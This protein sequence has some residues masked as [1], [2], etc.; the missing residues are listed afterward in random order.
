MPYVQIAGHRPAL[1]ECARWRSPTVAAA[2]KS[3]SSVLVPAARLPGPASWAFSGD[4]LHG[5]MPPPSSRRASSNRHSASRTL[6]APPPAISSLGQLPTPAVGACGSVAVA[7]VRNPAQKRPAQES[8]LQYCATP[9]QRGASPFGLAIAS[10]ASPQTAERVYY[11]DIV[12]GLARSSTHSNRRSNDTLVRQVVSRLPPGT[13]PYKAL[14]VSSS[15]ANK[16]SL[17]RSVWC[18]IVSAIPRVREKEG[19]CSYSKT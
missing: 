17:A 4:L 16:Q 12:E 10:E 19:L 6:G 11:Y 18:T 5:A 13:S 8:A 14:T 1:A 7:G 2:V 9:A 15:V 3:P